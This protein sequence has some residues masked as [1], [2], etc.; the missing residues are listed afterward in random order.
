MSKFN[1][2][3]VLIFG[4]EYSNGEKTLYYDDLYKI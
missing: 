1:E 3:S 2:N 4:G